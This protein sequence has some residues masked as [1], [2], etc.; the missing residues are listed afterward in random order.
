M[1]NK[2]LGQ[3]AFWVVNKA[4]AKILKCNDSALLLSD[5][6]DKYQYFETENSLID[7]FF[8]Y[9]SDKIEEN[10]N[11]SYK[12]QKKCIELLKKFELI[13]TKLI[14]V[15]A[16]L[17]FTIRQNKIFQM[18]QTSI[19]QMEKLELPKSQNIIKDNNNRNIIKEYDSEKNHTFFLTDDTEQTYETQKPTETA[20]ISTI[21]PK[22]VQTYQNDILSQYKPPYEPKK[23]F[24]KVGDVVRKIKEE[25]S[26]DWDTFKIGCS[27]KNDSSMLNSAMKN[28]WEDRVVVRDWCNKQDVP[29]RDWDAIYKDIKNFIR[30]FAKLYYK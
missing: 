14:G 21:I 25:H 12:K 2:I 10:L 8:F 13:E 20:Q 17:H 30:N 19:A 28:W 29:F 9:T 18:L 6:V 7:G 1:I 16:K 5:L 15:P 24:N 4:I 3:T 26:I 22:D 11:I 23:Q 27:I